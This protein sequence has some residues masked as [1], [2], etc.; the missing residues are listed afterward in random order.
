MLNTEQERFAALASQT[1][2]K[3]NGDEIPGEILP[4]F[5]NQEKESFVNDDFISSKQD[6]EMSLIPQQPG[7]NKIYEEMLQRKDQLSKEK[8]WMYKLTR[9]DV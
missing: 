9:P 5:K 7:M 3:R 8:L 4:D 2:S 1:Q 6:R